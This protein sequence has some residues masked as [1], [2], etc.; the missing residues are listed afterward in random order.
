M[1]A[2]QRKQDQ[3]K[4]QLELREGYVH[5]ELLAERRVKIEMASDCRCRPGVP[6]EALDKHMSDK[7]S[8]ADISGA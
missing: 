1:V 2:K 3:T 8:I 7:C 4:A 5:R 6:V